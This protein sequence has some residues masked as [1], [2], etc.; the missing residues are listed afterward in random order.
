[1]NAK[2]EFAER[3]KN[4]LREA[5]VYR[6]RK[7]AFPPSPPPP[8]A[9][10]TLFLGKAGEYSVASE[11]LFW[12]FNVSVLSD[13]LIPAQTGTKLTSRRAAQGDPRCRAHL[14]AR[15]FD[16]RSS[17]TVTSGSRFFHVPLIVS[18]CAHNRFF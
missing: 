11:L 13:L 2:A 4:A 14:S 8:P 6:L 17:V 10:N 18:F 15:L 3:L 5:G 9:T 16:K 1:M 7:T 12:G